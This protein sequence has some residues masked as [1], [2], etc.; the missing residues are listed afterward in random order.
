MSGNGRLAF[1]FHDGKGR[2][3]TGHRNALLLPSCC[4]AFQSFGFTTGEATV[5]STKEHMVLN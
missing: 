1:R 2:E 3:V 5:P 4:N